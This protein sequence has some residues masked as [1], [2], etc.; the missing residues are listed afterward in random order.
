M[1]RS[2]LAFVAAAI[3]TAAVPVLAS[4]VFEF[5]AKNGTVTFD[6]TAHQQRL[7]GDCAKCHQGTPGKIG[8]NRD[9]AHDMC[10]NCHREMNGPTRC[11]DCHKR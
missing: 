8:I 9:V 10:T 7:N 1:K 2:Y 11:N 3:L 6:H 4:E 5:K